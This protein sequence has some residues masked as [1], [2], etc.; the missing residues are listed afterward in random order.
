[1]GEI[2]DAVV[3]GAGL[4]GLSSAYHLKTGNYVVLE[5]ENHVGGLCASKIVDAYIFDFGTHTFFTQDQSVRELLAKLLP[6]L[7]ISHI[8]AA[9]VYMDGV[10][11]KYPFETN[12]V[13]LPTEIKGECIQGIK[14]RDPLA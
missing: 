9:Y 12:L 14:R 11:I 13:A 5:K 4:A 1:M 7:L 10:Y 2:Y 8:R 6:N 3:L